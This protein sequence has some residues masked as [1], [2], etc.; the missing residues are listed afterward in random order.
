[1]DLKKYTL[2]SNPIIEAI[3]WDDTEE[4]FIAIQNFARYESPTIRVNESNYNIRRKE[5]DLIIRN[6]LGMSIMEL[7]DYIF[8][9]ENSIGVKILSRSDFESKYKTELGTKTSV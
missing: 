9:P 2:I 1:M 8:R 4:T 3:Q 6:R 7:G 5:S